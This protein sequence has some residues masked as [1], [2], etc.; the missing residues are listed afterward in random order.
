MLFGGFV[1]GSRVNSVFSTQ[2]TAPNSVAWS[3]L[4]ASEQ[5]S[6]VMPAER[7]AHSAV[8]NGN[9]IFVFGG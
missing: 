5:P 4:R 8:G 3:L 2:F 1:G 9:S 7:N 6:K